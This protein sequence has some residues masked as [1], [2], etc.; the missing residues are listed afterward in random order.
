MWSYVKYHIWIF[1]RSVLILHYLLQMFSCA[2]DQQSNASTLKYKKNQNRAHPLRSPSASQCISAPL[3]AA[4]W[5]S[6]GEPAGWNPIFVQLESIRI[7]SDKMMNFSRSVDL[8]KPG[9]LQ[10]VD[11]MNQSLFRLLVNVESFVSGVNVMKHH[12]GYVTLKPV[13]FSWGAQ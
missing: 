1:N 7:Q 11:P 13:Q 12:L 4:R 9:K 8:L 3:T 2:T 5:A 6:P 10:V